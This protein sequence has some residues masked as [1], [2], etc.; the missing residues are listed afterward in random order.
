MTDQN[1]DRATLRSFLLVERQIYEARLWA[2][3]WLALTGLLLFALLCVL[4]LMQHTPT[5][6]D[7]VSMGVIVLAGG[8]LSR[9]ERLA[10]HELLRFKARHLQG[11]MK[12]YRTAAGAE[13]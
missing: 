4:L 7:L 11:R 12:Y 3:Q 6:T 5:R 9:R 13:L 8:Y 1:A 10:K 2:Q